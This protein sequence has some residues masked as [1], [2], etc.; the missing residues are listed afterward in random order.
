MT[1]IKDIHLI[2]WADFETAY[3]KADKVPNYL[4]NLF[5]GDKKL[6]MDATHELWCGLCHQHAYISNAALPSYNY[7][8][9]G[10]IT[11]DDELKVELLDI[12]KGFAYCTTQE[13]YKA[14]KAQMQSWENELRKKLIADLNIFKQLSTN[15]EELISV[16]AQDIVGFL[17]A[18]I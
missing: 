9:N 16:F 14:T 1:T 11:L 10:F 18:D 15:N 7:I 8:K 13:Y 6:A 4:T 2:N 17:T 12:I 5:S 3:G